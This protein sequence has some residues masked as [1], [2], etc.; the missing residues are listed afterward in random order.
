VD[1]AAFMEAVTHHAM[2][3]QKKDDCQDDYKQ[4]LSNS[5]RGWLSSCRVRRIRMGCHQRFV[6]PSSGACHGTVI[7]D[8]RGLANLVL[9]FAASVHGRKSRIRLIAFIRFSTSHFSSIQKMILIKIAY[10]PIIMPHP[11]PLA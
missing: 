7:H 3:K 11:T 8:V 10:S 5:E 4:E 1:P 9:A 2:A 6:S